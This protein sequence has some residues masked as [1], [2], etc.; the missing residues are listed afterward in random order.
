MEVKDPYEIKRLI[1]KIFMQCYA[2][3]CYNLS[4]NREDPKEHKKLRQKIELKIKR[5]VNSLK[6]HED[7]I[8]IDIQNNC[9]KLLFS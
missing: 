5:I 2:W 8:C 9:R 7:I 1:I 6:I 4:K 3:V